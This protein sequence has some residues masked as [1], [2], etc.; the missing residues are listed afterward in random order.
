MSNAIVRFLLFMVPTALVVKFV[1]PHEMGMPE[2]LVYI[3]LSVAIV[4]YW[5]FSAWLRIY[6]TRTAITREDQESLRELKK[7]V[8]ELK[9]KLN[10]LVMRSGLGI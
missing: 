6:Q 4:G 9:T 3:M 5:A 8:A 7:D 2:A 10:A 1:Q